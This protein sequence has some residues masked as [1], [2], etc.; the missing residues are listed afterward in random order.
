MKFDSH[1]GPFDLKVALGTALD[2]LVPVLQQ[3]HRDDA[4]QTL[5]DI[6]ATLMDQSRRKLLVPEGDLLEDAEDEPRKEKNDSFAARRRAEGGHVYT[7]YDA[8]A[9]AEGYVRNDDGSY[10]PDLRRQPPVDSYHAAR[11]R[12]MKRLYGESR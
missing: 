3:G 2:N 10:S 6:V 12:M 5:T 7:T 11:E 1:A 8:R 9:A 4:V